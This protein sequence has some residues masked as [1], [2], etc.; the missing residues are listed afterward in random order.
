MVTAWAISPV[1]TF[2]ASV[3]ESL[4]GGESI[5]EFMLKYELGEE[6]LLVGVMTL[7]TVGDSIT[8]VDSP[9][10]TGCVPTS[11]RE[12][13]RGGGDTGGFGELND[14]EETRVKLSIDFEVR[15]LRPSSIPIGL[16]NG[17][18]GPDSMGL[19]KLVIGDANDELSGENAAWRS[20][21]LMPLSPACGAWEV[22]MAENSVIKSWCGAVLSV[23]ACDGPV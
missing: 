19:S 7:G 8:V 12:D 15:R 6:L 21:A 22:R 2:G 11:C 4:L 17:L 3:A 10:G 16:A 18:V 1:S 9:N 23:F 5:E 13:L 14:F 20:S